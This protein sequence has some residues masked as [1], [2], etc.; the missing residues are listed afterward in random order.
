MV[1]PPPTDTNTSKRPSG[2]G[3][4]AFDA[5]TTDWVAPEFGAHQQLTADYGNV[6]KPL[7]SSSRRT[8]QL[9]G[10]LRGGG[11]PDSISFSDADSTTSSDEEP[12]PAGIRSSRGNNVKQT[13]GMGYP[14]DWNEEFQTILELPQDDEQQKLYK[15]ERLSALAANFQHT[16]KACGKIIISEKNLPNEYRTISI[17]PSSFFSLFF[18]L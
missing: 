16:A 12:E 18:F 10:S 8:G 4:F 9:R 5:D 7:S 15:Y 2:A 14:M 17:L 6:Q 11:Q 13:A 1:H 3:A